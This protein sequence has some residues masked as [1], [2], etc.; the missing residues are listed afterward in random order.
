[1]ISGPTKYSTSSSAISAQPLTAETVVENLGAPL[2]AEAD[3][4]LRLQREPT[5]V[6]RARAVAVAPVEGRAPKRSR[7]CQPPSAPPPKP[8]LAGEGDLVF[9]SQP[10][11]LNQL[12]PYQESLVGYVYR[13]T[14]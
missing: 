8:E 7:R 6:R 13:W 3:T 10:I 5:G 14:K 1:M 4:L 2:V 12:L 11:P 9:K